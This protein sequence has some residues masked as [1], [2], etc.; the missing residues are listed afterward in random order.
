MLELAPFQE[1][2]HE[3]MCGPASLKIVLE[4]FGVHKGEEEL[5]ALMRKTDIGSDAAG[6][7]RAAGALGFEA[8]VRD[9]SDFDDIRKWLDKR[10][11]VIVDWFTRGRADYADSEV[12]DGHYS[13]VSG[14]DDEYIYLQDPEIGGMRKIGR[15]DFKKVWFDFAG[16][17]ITPDELIVRQLIAVYPK[18]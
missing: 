16:E 9:N 7:V 3:S 10:V 15:N 18:G 2:L 17:F 8:D 13:V 5:A 1:T 6:F 14:L 12:A 11:P 4:Y